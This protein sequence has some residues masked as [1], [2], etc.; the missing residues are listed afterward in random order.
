[1]PEKVF[2]GC[3]DIFTQWNG[4]FPP[5]SPLVRIIYIMLN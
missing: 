5:A 1:M 4:Q 3:G 2:Y